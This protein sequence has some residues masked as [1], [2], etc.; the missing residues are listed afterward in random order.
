MFLVMRTYTVSH[1]ARRV[2]WQV[3][4]RPFA[5]RQEA[6]NFRSFCEEEYREENPRA[7]HRFFIVETDFPGTLP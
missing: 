3:I 6:E 5:T 2:L 7:Q 4:S 1:V